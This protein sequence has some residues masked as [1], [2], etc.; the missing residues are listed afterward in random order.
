MAPYYWCKRGL[1]LIGT[2]VDTK[3]CVFPG[4]DP[5]SHKKQH[6]VRPK[7]VNSEQF[8]GAL[9]RRRVR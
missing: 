8:A 3:T 6:L 7:R 4:S 2:Q 5:P 1:R 9:F